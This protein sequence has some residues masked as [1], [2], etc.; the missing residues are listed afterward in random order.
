[1][2]LARL[3]RDPAKFASAVLGL[4]VVV[5]L[6]A[7]VY[8]SRRRRA[9]APPSEPEPE[10]EDSSPPSQKEPGEVAA[11]AGAELPEAPAEEQAADPD[12]ILEEHMTVEIGAPGAYVAG[13][14]AEGPIMLRGPNVPPT[15]AGPH[16]AFRQFSE[17]DIVTSS[18]EN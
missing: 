13:Q 5:V 16:L 14:R 18:F 1:M 7:I 9:V 17:H 6:L 2:D 12:Q 3:T 8:S 10:A 4:A 11:E 15:P